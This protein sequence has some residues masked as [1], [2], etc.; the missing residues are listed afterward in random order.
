[1]PK[2]ARINQAANE[3]NQYVQ[4]DLT[5][6]YRKVLKLQDKRSGEMKNVNVSNS[7][8]W[9]SAAAKSNDVNSTKSAQRRREGTRKRQVK[10]NGKLKQREQAGTR[11]VRRQLTPLSSGRNRK[12]ILRPQKAQ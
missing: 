1:M 6:T 12:F 11:I 4:V 5:N 8:W 10:Q 3:A 2:S 7:A 9:T